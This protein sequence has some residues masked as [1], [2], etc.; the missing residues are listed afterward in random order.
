MAEMAT[1]GSDSY[2][3]FFGACLQVHFCVI[4]FFSGLTKCLGS[5]WWNGSNI[6]RALI[7]PPFNVIDADILVRGKSVFPIVGVCYLSAR[8]W[9]SIFYLEQQDT[10]YLADLY[11]RDAPPDRTRDG[12]V[13]FFPCDDYSQR[14]GVRP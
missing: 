4:Y 2:S 6:W 12:N 3:V 10:Q 5:G 9:L 8:N 1:E 11:L 13:S 14:G 7:R